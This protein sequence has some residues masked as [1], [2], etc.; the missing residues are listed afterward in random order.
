MDQG[1]NT[2]ARTS[3]WVAPAG[4]DP[5]T[6]WVTGTAYMGDTPFEMPIITPVVPGL[7]Q[8]G[9]VEGMDLGSRFEFIVSL[10]PWHR[11]PIAP[12]VMRY[13][14]KL[15]DGHH[16]DDKLVRSIAEGVNVYRQTRR[17]LVHCQAGLNRSALIVGAALILDGMDP[18]EAIGLLRRQRSPAVL[19]NPTFERYLREFKA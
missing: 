4:A 12:G 11:W 2:V 14:F 5:F 13:E 7:W 1:K 18:D 19:C 6:H 16:V 15:F 9:F 10:Y 3:G 17:T 8:G